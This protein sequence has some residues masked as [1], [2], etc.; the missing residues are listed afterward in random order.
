M[1]S[2]QAVGVFDS[3]MG[4]LTA[5]KAI[6][7]LL[8][9]EDIVFFADTLRM[10]YGDK[11]KSTIIEYA[12]QNIKFLK[13]C[14]TKI[15]LAACGTISSYL[16]LA[17]SGEEVLGVIKPSCLEAAQ[18][19]SNRSIGVLAT[20][21]TIESNSYIKC[22]NKIDS[23]IHCWQR[24]CPQLAPLIENGNI[25][26][27]DKNLVSTLQEC[28]TPLLEQDVDTIILGCTH[29]PIVEPVIREIFGNKLNLIN[30]GEQLAKSLQVTLKQ[31][32]L[33]SRYHVGEPRLRICV[34]GDE[35]SFLKNAQLFLGKQEKFSIERV[36]II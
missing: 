35:K 8:P 15:I 24:S 29:Y 12:K 14:N 1:K 21:A 18:K 33:E 9:H 6:R 20:R 13:S 22:L 7:E 10:P 4:G 27:Q 19:T 25:S 11:P 36:S 23:N 26:V 5:V 34:S 3:G 2:N 30:S 16:S 17:K 32:Q 28:I 31:K